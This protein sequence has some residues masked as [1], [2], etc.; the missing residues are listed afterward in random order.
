MKGRSIA[1]SGAVLLLAAASLAVAAPTERQGPTACS[2]SL[3][4]YEQNW[5]AG[6]GL[7]SLYL[8]WVASGPADTR[9]VGHLSSHVS[10]LAD[11]RINRSSGLVVPAG[12]PQKIRWSIRGGPPEN[13]LDVV[14]R[15]LD[16][17][18]SFRASFRIAAGGTF[19]SQISFPAAGC[20]QLVVRTG[21][22]RRTVVVRAVEPAPAGTCDA[23]PVEDGRV[24][25]RPTRSGISAQW[26]KQTA[27]GG[28][29][30]QGE[31]RLATGELIMKVPWSSTRTTGPI[32]HLRGTRL[33]ARGAFR[34]SFEEAFSPRYFW[35]AGVIVPEAGCW[36]LTVRIAG[37]RGT[38][39]AAGILVA[40]SAG[41]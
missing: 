4:R 16:G 3:V 30:I 31:S 25:L 24:R 36:L 18:G 34:Q 38:P 32:L 8:P 28:A 11:G 35:P 27:N 19:P 12:V 26:R 14:G 33:D 17:A 13:R 10:Q 1:T 7:A 41:E 20:W 39:S 2:P 9:L 21:V 37:A 22:M 29:L 40:Q 15:R 5:D 6:R 23:S